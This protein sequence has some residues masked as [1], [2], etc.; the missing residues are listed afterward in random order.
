MRR[1]AS[2]LGQELLFAS[3]PL[4]EYGAAVAI[5]F[6]L[7]VLLYKEPTLRRTFGSEYDQFCANIPRWLPRLRPWRGPVD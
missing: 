4:L 7:F 5:G 6:H 3:T 2:I 1:L